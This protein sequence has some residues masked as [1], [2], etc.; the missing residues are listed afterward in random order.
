M[1]KSSQSTIL[2]AD[3]DVEYLTESK[4]RTIPHI[5]NHEGVFFISL[6]S[7]ALKDRVQQIILIL[8]RIFSHVTTGCGSGATYDRE[9]YIFC[10]KG[11]SPNHDSMPE[12]PL[13]EHKSKD[14]DL[15]INSARQVFSSIPYIYDT[16]Y[17]EFYPRVIKPRPFTEDALDTYYVNFEDNER[18]QLIKDAEIILTHEARNAVD[19]S[20]SH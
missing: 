11:H 2:I 12:L 4:Y 6:S 10:K 3:V 8:R 1:L 16:R 18:L 19:L 17:P 7:K 9:T 15:S 14:D 13:E 5:L 20:H